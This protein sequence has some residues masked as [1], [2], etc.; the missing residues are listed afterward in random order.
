MCSGTD[1]GVI[2]IAPIGEVVPAFGAGSGVVG[3][4]V[5]RQPG[6]GEPF[7]RHLEERGR[8]VFLGQGEFAAPCECSEGGAGLDRQLI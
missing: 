7:L 4:L 1:P 5:S 6:G 8:A 3:D 2:L